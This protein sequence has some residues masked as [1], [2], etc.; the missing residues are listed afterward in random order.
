MAGN[1]FLLD[2][3]VFIWWM[4]EDAELSKDIKL[5]L[6]NPQNIIYLSTVSVWEM[7]IKKTLRKLRL[8]SEWKQTISNSHFITL[9]VYLKHTL[10]LESLP[11]RHKDPFDRMLIAQ[12]LSEEV[13]LI[14]GDEKIWR[15]GLPVIKA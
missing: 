1:K 7:I 10:R 13:T 15:Y 6:K 11:I 12:A 4:K 8:P 3:Q 14:S 5:I 2:T 9:P